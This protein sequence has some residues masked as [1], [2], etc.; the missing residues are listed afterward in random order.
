VC[1]VNHLKGHYF[2]EHLFYAYVS[3]NFAFSRTT[4]THIW[5]EI[6]ILF[7]TLCSAVQEKRARGRREMSNIYQMFRHSMRKMED[8]LKVALAGKFGMYIRSS[9]CVQVMG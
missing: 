5:P 6:S 1:A 3:D 8:V 9:F 7:L 4:L 2:P